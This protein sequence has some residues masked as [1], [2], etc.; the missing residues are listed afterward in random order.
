MQ[1]AYEL[2]RDLALRLRILQE[3]CQAVFCDA[4]AQNDVDMQIDYEGHDA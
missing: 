1:A 4:L 2:D 3:T